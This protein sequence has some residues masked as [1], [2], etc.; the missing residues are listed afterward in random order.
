MVEHQTLTHPAVTEPEPST[1]SIAQVNS[2]FEQPWWLDALAPGRWDAA[3]V[4]RGE[5][6]VARLPYVRRRRLGLT[7]VGQPRFT[8]T[9]GPWLAP[10]EGKYARRLETEKKLLGQLIDQLPPFDFYRQGFSPTL[11]NWL[12]FYWAGFAA[13][14]RYTYRIEDLTDLDRVKSEFQD[15]VRRGIRKAEGAVEVDHDYPL[16][17]LLRLDE[18]SYARR[19]ASSAEAHELVRRLDD[20]CAA[21]G[22][23]RIFAAVDGKGRVQAALYVIWDDRTCYAL[24]NARDPELQTHGS[25]TLLY[26]EAI[27]LASDVSRVFDFEGSMLEPVEHYFRG[28]GGRQTPYFL[29]SKAG[30]R[31][32]P[33][34][35]AWSTREAFGRVVR[36]RSDRRTRRAIGP[37]EAG[38][39]TDLSQ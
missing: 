37:A 27:R 32:K 5:K 35:A 24:V 11:T 34:L 4:R 18:Q 1:D 19:G 29:I 13:T 31:A 8:Q 22:A 28:F 20:A 2:I 26:W 15:H 3:V 36:S 21:R 16:E 38:R 12:P 25:N 39:A 10:T 23:R 14:I 30:L 6:V 33:V 17:D 9:L 7:I